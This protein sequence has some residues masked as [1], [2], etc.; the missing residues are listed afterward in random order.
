MRYRIDFGRIFPGLVLFLVGLALLCLL[1]LGVVILY[2]FS[3]LAGAAGA[4]AFILEL[5]IVPALMIAVGV[6]TIITGVSWW[7]KGGVGWMAGIAKARARADRLR[8]SARVGEVIGVLITAV[9]FLFV[10]ENQLRGVAFFT[11][12]FGLT[13]Q[14]LFYAPLFTGMALS[15]AR[16]FYGRRNGVRPFDSLNSLFLAIAAFNCWTADCCCFWTFAATSRA[17]ESSC[18]VKP[19]FSEVT[20]NWPLNW[21]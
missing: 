7:G 20:W 11:S 21:A 1:A 13:A 3:F 6:I 18:A 19:S 15:L 14:F 12:G 5:M 8:L 17:R 9:I 2:F 10:Y 4:T 16:A